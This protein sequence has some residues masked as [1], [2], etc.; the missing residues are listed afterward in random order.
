MYT[1]VTDAQFGDRVWIEDDG[2]GYADTGAITPVAGMV[3][4][5][6]N[7]TETYTTTTS[8]A[9]YY[10]FTV[11]ADTYTVTYGTVPPSYGAVVSSSVVSGTTES[12]NAGSYAAAGDPDA[13]HGQHTVVTV[14]PGEA[15]WQVD[16]AFTPIRYSLGNRL[17]IDDGAGILANRNN[18]RYDIDEVPVAEGVL[19]ELLTI[20]GTLVATTTTD[21][22]GYYRFDNLLAGDYRVHIPADEFLAGGLLAGMSSSS[23]ITDTFTTG[24]NNLDHGDDD[25]SDGVT[26]AVITLS[27]NN[28]T[29]DVDGGVIGAGANGTFGDANDN[30]T[31]DFGFVPPLAQFGDRVW[32][33]DDG[34]GLASTGVIA[35]VMGM[36]ITAT[37]GTEIYTT[38]TNAGGYYSF[39][40]PAD[41]YTVSY[42]AVPAQYGTVIVSAAPGGS[43]E[44]GSA[45][46]YAETGDPDM[47]HA[48]NTTVTVATGETN[49]HVDFAF[50]QP[51]PPMLVTGVLTVTKAV[52]WNGTTADAGQQF[53]YTIDGPDGFTPI[54]DSISDGGVITYAMPLGVYTVTE[55]SPGAG[56]VT[57]Y[58]VDSVDSATM[59]VIEL[60]GTENTATLA[61]TPI[62]G[63]VFNDYNSDG[64]ITANG[65]ITDTGVQSVTVT[66][67][68]MNGA[69]C[70]STQSSVSGYYTLTTAIL[71]CDGPIGSSL[72][73]CLLVMS[74]VAATHRMGQPCSLLQMWGMQITLIWV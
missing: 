8:V 26:S 52:D 66:A 17:W 55:T 37:N 35:P 58:T 71:T 43:S 68:G 19:V 69:N 74:Q 14:A 56:W 32:I 28:P 64:L 63:R 73:I 25:T 54:N 7:G 46:S 3:I 50:Y 1:P 62:T 49:W 34:D 4:T 57:T 36:V 23:G 38:T 24:E 72:L 41:T 12:G 11:P 65:V 47:G 67:Y 33:E 48:N 5:A 16:F 6:T 2:D 31:V 53:A 42:G 40:V 21:A 60:T 51:L 45:G 22:A 70:G 61:A 9:G 30:L 59:G 10:S 18:G 29:G 27:A 39:T 20:T 13:N 15:N 44:S